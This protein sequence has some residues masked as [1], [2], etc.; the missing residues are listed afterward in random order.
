VG[1]AIWLEGTFMDMAGPF[2]RI[3]GCGHKASLS[4]IWASVPAVQRQQ[5]ERRL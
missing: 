4:S 5:N 2:S 1:F 3:R